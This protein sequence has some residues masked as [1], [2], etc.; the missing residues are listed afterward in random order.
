LIDHHA[1]FGLKRDPRFGGSIRPEVKADVRARPDDD[2]ISRADL[3]G[4]MLQRL[5]GAFRRTIG[6]VIPVISDVKRAQE[7]AIFQSLDSGNRVPVGASSARRVGA[8]RQSLALWAGIFERAEVPEGVK[9]FAQEHL[10][11]LEVV[12]PLL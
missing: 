1:R 8:I 2:R 4:G 5:P 12:S 3:V 10:G 11:F 7:E 6:P 9:S